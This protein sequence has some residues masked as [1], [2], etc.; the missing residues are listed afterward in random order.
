MFAV[1]GNVHKAAD[2]YTV[3]AR[4][5]WRVLAPYTGLLTVTYIKL[6]VV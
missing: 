2:I 1:L 5:L 6:F 4:A 3:L